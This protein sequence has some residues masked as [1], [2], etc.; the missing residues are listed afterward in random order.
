MRAGDGEGLGDP[1][2]KSFPLELAHPRHDI[3]GTGRKRAGSLWPRHLQVIEDHLNSS[4]QE[5][6]LIALRLKDP[7][8]L[9]KLRD[10]PG[11]DSLSL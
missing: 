7:P 6:M 4:A 8:R 10:Q 9:G 1:R 5:I 11:G 2:A 3:Y